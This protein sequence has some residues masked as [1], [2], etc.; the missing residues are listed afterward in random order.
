MLGLPLGANLNPC[1]WILSFTHL[2]GERIRF[3][4]VRI[5]APS[6]EYSGLD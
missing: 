5:E 1:I 6:V 4:L 3:H 2:M